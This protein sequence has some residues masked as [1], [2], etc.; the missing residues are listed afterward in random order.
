MKQ[1]LLDRYGTPEEVTRCADV[2]DVGPPGPGEVVFEVLLFPINPTDVW[3]CKGES[4]LRPPLP[5]TPGSECAGRVAAVGAGVTHVKPGDLVTTM[6]R[7]NW[8]QRRKVA[9]DDVIALP[10]GTD[11]P[12]AAMVRINPPTALLMLTDLVDF[13]P[14]DWVLQNVANSAVGRLLIPLARA[15]GLRTVN[16]VRRESLVAELT[17]LGADACVVD[18]PNLPEQVKAATGGTPIRLGIDAVGGPATAR[19]GACVADG[20]TVCTYGSMSGEDPVMRRSDLIFRRVTLVGFSFG[21]A[22]A[23]RS[24]QEVRALYAGLATQI[25]AGTLHVPVEKIYPIEEIRAALRHAQQGERRGKI[26]VAPN[27]PVAS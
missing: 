27:G 2:P 10:A 16:V 25:M 11:L 23:R 15:R 22:L 26:L 17:L 3:F 12:Q 4:R 19:I 24:P 8:T 20:G 18:G 21:T 14:G 7:E 5:A 6:Q 13:E 1:V 9:G